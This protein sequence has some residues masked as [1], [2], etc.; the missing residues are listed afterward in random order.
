MNWGKIL[1]I[2]RNNYITVYRYF[3]AKIMFHGHGK[4]KWNVKI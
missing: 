1:I 2:K 4:Q 3:H